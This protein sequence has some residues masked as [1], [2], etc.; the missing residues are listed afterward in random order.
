VTLAR[1][2]GRGENLLGRRGRLPNSL[3]AHAHPL[4][5][6]KRGDL[7]DLLERNKQKVG[8]ANMS[9]VRR[10]SK[11]TFYA[12]PTTDREKWRL[13]AHLHGSSI[14]YIGKFDS[15]AEAEAW[16]SGPDGEAW[17]QTSY[18]PSGNPDVET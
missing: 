1:W 5:V 7:A 9:A 10:K 12:V 13:L 15:K 18:S 6:G 4:S 2:R 3:L 16:A 14:K 17:G 11:V 8:T